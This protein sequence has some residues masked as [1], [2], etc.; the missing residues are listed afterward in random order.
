MG[1]IIHFKAEKILNYIAINSSWRASNTKCEPVDSS[2]LIIAAKM[3][4]QYKIDR[5]QEQDCELIILLT[6]C[7]YACDVESTAHRQQRIKIN[8][9]ATNKPHYKC[10]H[11]TISQRC[12]SY[13]ANTACCNPVSSSDGGSERGSNPAIQFFWRA[14]RLFGFETTCIKVPEIGQGESGLHRR[15]GQLPRLKSVISL[16]IDPKF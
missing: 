7:K 10:G 12:C 4:I 13:F 16:L 6:P 2:R 9:L 14:T 11:Q 1:C 8:P 3:I 15:S 5:K